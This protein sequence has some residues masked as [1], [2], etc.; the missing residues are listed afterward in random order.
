MKLDF[1]NINIAEEVDFE[2]IQEE[3]EFLCEDYIEEGKD[4]SFYKDLLSKL[5]IIVGFGRGFWAGVKYYFYLVYHKETKKFYWYLRNYETDYGVYFYEI[6]KDAEIFNLLQTKSI[7]YNW[8]EFDEILDF[9]TLYVLSLGT[10]PDIKEIQDNYK[11]TPLEEIFGEDTKQLR[12]AL[13]CF[14]PASSGSKYP[15]KEFDK[16]YFDPI[17]KKRLDKQVDEYNKGEFE[18]FRKNNTLYI[19]LNGDTF[20][21]T[22]TNE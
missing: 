2:N 22:N 17:H 6:K 7:R 9:N 21:L 20:K 4:F 13:M 5:N 18:V 16:I 19:K 14:N 3:W 8:N 10:Y 15:H 1:T 11:P 12:I